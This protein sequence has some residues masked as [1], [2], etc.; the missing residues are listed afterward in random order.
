MLLLP[1]VFNNSALLPVAVLLLPM[2]FDINALLPV[3]VLSTPV[4]FAFNA[5]KPNA[6]FTLPT[7]FDDN[8][9]TPIAVLAIPAV[10]ADSAPLPI[11]V[12]LAKFP[13]PLPT[14]TLFIV[15]ST[16]P[17]SCKLTLF[18]I[19]LCDAETGR[20]LPA[21]ANTNAVVAICVVFVPTIAV[22]A[23][24]TPVNVGEAVLAF[25][26]NCVCIELVASLFVLCI[27]V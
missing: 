7:V 24:A 9:F 1:V 18:T 12:L 4:V 13:L 10:F 21:F 11:A 27:G 23:D 22:G 20:L 16:P 8:A 19:P 6:A 14:L 15:L 25:E 3:A 26:F 2:V 17:S 5:P